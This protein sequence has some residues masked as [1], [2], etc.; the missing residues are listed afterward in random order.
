MNGLWERDIHG[1]NPELAIYF[2]VGRGDQHAKFMYTIAMCGDAP[3]MPADLIHLFEIACVT[4]CGKER[5]PRTTAVVWPLLWQVG[6]PRIWPGLEQ[7]S[8]LKGWRKNN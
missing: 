4:H 5:T 8:G 3:K 2:H 7:K 1:G 6:W